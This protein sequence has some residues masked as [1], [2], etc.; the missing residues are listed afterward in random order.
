M[1]LILFKK[2]RVCKTDSVPRTKL[3]RSSDLLEPVL[4]LGLVAEAPAY[5]GEDALLPGAHQQGVV[6]LRGAVLVHLDVRLVVQARRR[7][8]A[9]HAHRRHP[10]IARQQ[11]VLQAVLYHILYNATAAGDEFIIIICGVVLC[12]N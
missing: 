5:D 2:F 3:Q 11:L 10:V 1:L 4:A 9:H 7:R 8:R 6:V 12:L